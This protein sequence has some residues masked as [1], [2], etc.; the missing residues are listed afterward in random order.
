VSELWKL[1]LQL[2]ELADA[3]EQV[4]ELKEN[5][6]SPPRSPAILEIV[7]ELEERLREVQGL[8]SGQLVTMTPKASTVL[9]LQETLQILLGTC[10]E[11]LEA[12]QE[13]QKYVQR[14]R[15]QSQVKK[16]WSRLLGTSSELDYAAESARTLLRL[17]RK[18]A[19]QVGRLEA[20]MK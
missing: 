4:T 19:S 3:L 10:A 13:V 5:L 14:Y 20:L 8:A 17:S 7:A 9:P 18:V 6:T 2:E 16:G 11:A 1:Q 15:S 12:L